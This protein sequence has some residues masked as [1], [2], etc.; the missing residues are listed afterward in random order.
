MKTTLIA[1]S[2][3]Y[4][5]DSYVSWLFF[6]SMESFDTRLGAL[7]SLAECFVRKYEYE[8][9]NANR[10]LYR[11][12]SCCKAAF[13]VK[14]NRFC[15]VCGNRLREAFDVWHWVSWLSDHHANTADSWGHVEMEQWVWSPWPG[16]REIL[17]TPW[18]HILYIPENGEHALT[19]ALRGDELAYEGYSEALDDYWKELPFL[20]ECQS[21]PDEERAKSRE[22]FGRLLDAPPFRI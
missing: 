5:E 22:S 10:P 18:G 14:D 2:C 7:Q 16:L 17:A 4:V 19:M 1:L 11:A 20:H 15:P 8:V 9:L 13:S 21:R 3:G 6:Q 12:G